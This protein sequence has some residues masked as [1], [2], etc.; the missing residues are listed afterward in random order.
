MNVLAAVRDV[1]IILLAS[2]GIILTII[3][4]ILSLVIMAKLG[5]ILDSLKDTVG[6][7]QGTT[8]FISDT[9]VKPIIKVKSFMSGAKR[10]ITALASFPKRKRGRGHGRRE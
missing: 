6:N 3:L 8:S 2:F 1:A 5:P 10:A 9:T 7:V 4:I